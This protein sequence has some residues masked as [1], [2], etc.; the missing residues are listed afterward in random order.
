VAY[1]DLLSK[2]FCSSSKATLI[3]PPADLGLQSWL[4]VTIGYVS[5]S[6]HADY[7]K[8]IEIVDEHAFED[9][10]QMN[11]AKIGVI[12]ANILY[13]FGLFREM[14]L[15]SLESFMNELRD[16]YTALPTDMAL[17]SI[18]KP[19]M[20]VSLKSTILFAHLLYLGAIMLIYRC[21]IGHYVRAQGNPPSRDIL[22]IPSSAAAQYLAEGLGK[23]IASVNNTI[24]NLI[25]S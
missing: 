9:I 4:S 15:L 21:I 5:S 22:S 7:I 16:W 12:K 25:F 1:L 13:K 10:V 3:L 11:L 6:W 20:S 2:V 8:D 17:S 19:S 18:A 14:T 23:L 24:Q